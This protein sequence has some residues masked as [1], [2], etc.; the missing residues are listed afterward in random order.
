VVGTAAVLSCDQHVGRLEVA[1]DQAGA[2]GCGKASARLDQ[3]V[4]QDVETRVFVLAPLPEG[5]AVDV[6]HCEEHRVVVAVPDR[7]DVVHRDHVRGC[8]LGHRLGLAEHA[9]TLTRIGLT[10]R[11]MQQLERNP[12]VELRIVG[13]VDGSHR[14]ATELR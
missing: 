13:R 2:M 3:D 8:E 12:T 7:P 9:V 11:R 6:L 1:V 5:E 4:E 10:D 14:S